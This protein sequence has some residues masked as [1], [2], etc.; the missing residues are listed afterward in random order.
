MPE[1]GAGNLIGLAATQARMKPRHLGLVASFL[2][3]VILPTLLSGFYLYTVAADQY[4]SRGGFSVRS[5]DNAST[6]E[7][8]GGLSALSTGT[9][10]DT[11]VLFEFMESQ[12]IVQRVDAELDLR[13]MFSKP[14][15]DPVFSLKERGPIEELLKFWKRMVRVDYDTR[16][17]L[18]ELQVNAF[19]PEDAQA[20]AKAIFQANSEVINNL[21]AIAREDITRFTRDELD[22]SLEA[23]KAARQEMSRFRTENQIVDPSADIAG[24]MGLVTSLQSQLSEALVEFD[25]LIIST[26]ER[27]PRIAETQRRIDVIQ[28]RIQEERKKFGIS[29]SVEDDENDYS[30]ILA[31]Y[32]AISIDLEYA[33]ESYLLARSAYQ[34]A[35]GKSRQQTRYL[36]AYLNPTLA[37]SA[38]YPERGLLLG[39]V[40]LFS[41]LSWSVLCLVYYSLRDRR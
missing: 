7:I 37:E 41:F 16:K 13:A 30:S 40:F 21:S 1:D 24:Q 22:Q 26:N 20:I 31:E 11:D 25:I 8:L 36:A 38:E 23:L 4:A 2:L 15:F 10:K 14:V 19:S 12:N 3:L 18:I 39:L 5:E 6:A 28:N 29:S 17:G 35:L 33:E 27:D 9:S 32:Q 34:D